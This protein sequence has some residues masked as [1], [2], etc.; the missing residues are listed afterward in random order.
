MFGDERQ[1]F[2]EWLL[3]DVYVY[4]PSKEQ[5]EEATQNAFVRGGYGRLVFWSF[6]GITSAEWKRLAMENKRA[7]LGSDD[8]SDCS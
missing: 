7:A 6:W 1:G 4:A 2:F 3:K 5:W 8:D